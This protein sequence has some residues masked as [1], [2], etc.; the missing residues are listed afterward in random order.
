M[1]KNVTKSNGIITVCKDLKINPGEAIAAGD[2]EMDIDMFRAVKGSI[3][4]GNAPEYVKKEALYTADNCNK[5][6]LSKAL[7][8]IFEI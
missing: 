2:S 4:M 7:N 3:A 6:G 1:P 8:K 5:G